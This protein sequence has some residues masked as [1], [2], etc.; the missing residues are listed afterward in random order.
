MKARR[1]GSVLAALALTTALLT[2]CGSSA[3]STGTGNTQV[4]GG[5]LKGENIRIAMINDIPSWD[6]GQAGTANQLE[7]A[8]GI[9]DTLIGVDTEGKL[10]PALA[11]EWRYTDDSRKVLE[12]K[13]RDDVTFSDG[14]KFNA[15]AAKANLD[16]FRESNGPQVNQVDGV[17]GT[18]VVDEKTIRIKLDTPN[19]ALEINLSQAAGL[20]ASPASLKD[21]SAETKPVG[22]GP[23]TLDPGSVRGNQYILKAREGY[24]KPELQ[25]WKMMTFRLLS[26]PAARLN[27][28]TAKQVD[29]ANIQPPQIA[30]AE[31]TGTK[32]TDWTSSVQGMLLLDREGKVAPELKDVRVRQAI[33]YAF[34][35]ELMLKEAVLGRGEVTSQMFAPGSSAYVEELDHAY[36]HDVAKAKQLMADAG[37]ANGFKVKIAFAKPSEFAAP[38]I[39]QELG[40]IGITVERVSIPPQDFQSS[41]SGGQYAMPWSVISQGPTWTMVQRV[42][43]PEAPYNAFKT[44]TP[45]LN[46]LLEETRNAGDAENAG[47]ELNRYLVDNAWFAPWYRVGQPLAYNPQVVSSVLKQA[48][49]NAP[50]IYSY[51]PAKK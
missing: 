29:V 41:I 18:E 31:K 28:L 25:H 33:N 4:P 22:S 50:S 44:Q 7:L 5:D 27:A 38:F 49:Q 48:F 21:G 23:Y 12:L 16:H 45:E 8:R 3:G 10:V 13:L 35:R 17:T 51:L 20:Q 26:D 24:W 42:V 30:Q 47:Q 32:V 46:K 39:V 6:P 11:T 37:Y 1:R 9:Y 15:E 36:P 40:E 2:A 14:A 34:D 43:S 19:P